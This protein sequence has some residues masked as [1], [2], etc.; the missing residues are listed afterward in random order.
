MFRFVSPL[1]LSIELPTGKADESES[2]CFDFPD[3]I[4][5]TPEREMDPETTSESKLQVPPGVQEFWNFV[6][7][8]FLFQ[9]LR[10]SQTKAIKAA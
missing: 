1:C 3:I 10:G 2:V 8:L 7:K 9:W 6:F 4:D 5:E